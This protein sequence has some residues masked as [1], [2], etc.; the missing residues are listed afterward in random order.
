MTINTMR[1]SIM[2]LSIVRFSIMTLSINDTHILGVY[3]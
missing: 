3:S 1:F 2:A